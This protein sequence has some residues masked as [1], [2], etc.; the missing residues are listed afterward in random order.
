MP[1]T[2]QQLKRIMHKSGQA[3]VPRDRMN[4]AGRVCET[5]LRKKLY[6]F[7]DRAALEA[8]NLLKY[9]A[10]NIREYAL[11]AASNLRI[12][13]VGNDAQ[14]IAW[15]RS[16]GSYATQQLVNYGQRVALIGYQY[17]VTAYAAGWYGRLWM[18]QQASHGDKRVQIRPM[19]RS[20]AE[21]AV[22]QPGLTEAVQGD[23]N[24]YDYFGDMWRDTFTQAVNASVAKVKRV[25]NS[26]MSTPQAV[27]PLLTQVNT[28]LGVDA[29]AKESAKGLYHAVQLPVRTAVMRSANH[30]SAEV[31]KTHT[32]LLLGA[33]WV[34]SRD[35]RVC[36][37]CSR[38]DGRIFV[39][40]SLVGIALFGLPPDGSHYGC[41]CT[42]IPLMLPVERADAPPEDSFDEWLDEWGY[43]DELSFFMDDTVLEST[44]L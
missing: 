32:E 7:E 41:R 23:L 43:A 44:Q 6:R 14:S 19:P 24:A 21:T 39:I 35:S 15:R 33:M 29:T 12:N 4:Y 8:Y 2:S 1:L 5:Y 22:L 42:I 13:K 38:Q 9:T 26:S 30:A 20:K 27:L 16:V 18:L 40:N 17:A 34:S 36:P 11:G 25:L 28:V 3:F 10:R 31:Y 37:L